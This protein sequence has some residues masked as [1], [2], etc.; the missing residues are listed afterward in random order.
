MTWARLYEDH[1]AVQAA[2]A[3]LHLGGMLVAGG[4]AIASDRA[5]LRARRRGAAERGWVLSELHA[6]HRAVIGGL[7]VV[8]ASGGL[9]LFADLPAYLASPIFWLKMGVVLLLLLNGYLLTRSEEALRS[10]RLDEGRG[11]PRLARAARASLVIW[12][13]VT[14]LGVAV[15]DFG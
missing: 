5:V 8:V 13:A 10:G 1:A 7:A 14:L 12:L 6:V 9:L 15:V 2:V 11:W 4:L 3:G